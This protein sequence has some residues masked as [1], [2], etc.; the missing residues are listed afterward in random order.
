M[1]LDGGCG[2]AGS[3]A[4]ADI[5]EAAKAGDVGEVERLLGQDP[6][7][8]DAGD[9]SGR[10]P[11]M[12]ASMR[13]HVGV[14]RWLLDK[15]AAINQREVQG[16]TALYLACYS[17]RAPVVMVLAERGAD[18][19]TGSF[20]GF[21][22]LIIASLG[23]HLK[24]VRFLLDHP[25]AKAAINHRDEDGKTALWVACCTGRGGVVR[26]LLESGADPTIP[27]NNGTT[28]I[29]IA[30]LLAPP[31]GVTAEC[32]WECV[33]AL[34][35]S[36]SPPFLP[37]PSTR[38][39][40]KLAERWPL[41]PG[42]GGR[43]RSGPTCSGRPGRWPISRGAARWRWRGGTRGRKGR[44]GRRWWIGWCTASR[45]TCFPT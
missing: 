24:V 32:Y 14:V 20:S 27:S 26:A 44:S 5:W 19:T 16:S 18:P 38:S 2:C 40:D 12:W 4:M 28:P 9:G 15:K 29:A 36:F 34:E 7:L 37:C 6:G 11:L 42:V 25:G 31:P 45:G 1:R 21:T 33:A 8:L 13:G 17:G 39:N 10:T 23:G 30:K 3:S 43:R 41:V 22:P 35:V